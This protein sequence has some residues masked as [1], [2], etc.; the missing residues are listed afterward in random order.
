LLIL[1]PPQNAAEQYDGGFMGTP[2]E[3]HGMNILVLV[4][5]KPNL[6]IALKQRARELAQRL[7]EAN[8]GLTFELVFDERGPGDKAVRDLEGRVLLTAPIRQQLI[9]EFLKPEHHAVLWVD[10]DLVSYPAD[11]PTH[12]LRR[13]PLGVSA[14]V[15]LLDHHADRFYDVAGF[16]EN[17]Q[18]ARVNYPWFNQ[19]GPEFDLDGVGCIYLVP[20]KVYH[21]GG[22]HE[23]VPGFTD[24][25]AVC[26]MAKRL[27]MPVR[28]Y[29]DLKA[30]HAYLPDFGESFHEP[31]ALQ[32]IFPPQRGAPALNTHL[33]T[34]HIS[35]MLI[36]GLRLHKAGS[37]PEAEQIFRTIL[38]MDPQ[39]VDAHHF[40]GLLAHQAGRFD[41]A[42]HWVQK[43]VELGGPRPIM[44]NNLGEAFRASNKLTE[45]EACYRKALEESSHMPQIHNNLGLV[46]H[47]LGELH[48]SLQ[49][50]DEALRLSAE[51]YAKAHRNK[52]RVLQELGRMSDAMASFDRA[53][54]LGASG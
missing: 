44:L 15:V 7:P 1:L 37:L 22:R 9:D 19:K 10:A 21:A 31:E 49:C 17:G 20:T 46:L 53:R 51:R 27:G 25:L 18:W 4:P 6:H 54:E 28:A 26:S 50:F 16:V 33:P 39:H 14:P 40:I 12:L 36:E 48:E 2:K 38:K 32:R 35:D 47:S 5:V 41:L 3:L 52:G 30:Y 45:A 8:P 43:A 23:N 13:N 29:G 24:H 42:I 34:Q 11:L